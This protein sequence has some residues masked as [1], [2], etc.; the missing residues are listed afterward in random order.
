MLI[1]VTLKVIAQ[2]PQP[3]SAAYSK[4]AVEAIGYFNTT[5]G[6]QAEFVNGP[7]YILAPPANKGSHYFQDK[8]YCTPSLIRF[9]NTWYK[10]VP[11]LYDV[12]NDEMISFSGNDLFVLKTEYLSDVFLLDHHFVRLT[13]GLSPGFYDLL[14]SGKS[15]V[16]AKR[17]KVNED[18]II[19]SQTVKFIL[20]DRSDLF[21]K[22]EGKYYP[23]TSKGALLGIF[24]DRRKDINQY[25]RDHKLDYKADKEAVTVAITAY[26]DQLTH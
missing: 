24:K 20:E 16:L 11:V 22:K 18:E 26:Y 17:T 12:F 15:Q 5:A 4:Q 23:V 14:Y 6:S 7:Q 25:I 2:A 13:A 10:D 21:I 19:Q 8:N 9:N 1:L 3:D